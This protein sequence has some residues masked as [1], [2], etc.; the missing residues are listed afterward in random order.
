MGYEKRRH[1]GHK[2]KVILKEAILISLILIITYIIVLKKVGF[3]KSLI[4]SLDV[5]VLGLII[6]GLVLILV[7]ILTGIGAIVATI[8]GVLA[9]FLGLFKFDFDVIWDTF[10]KR[11]KRVFTLDY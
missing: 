4:F 3:Y 2:F 5:V 8:L 7:G 6:G 10:A 1:E 11:L 9:S